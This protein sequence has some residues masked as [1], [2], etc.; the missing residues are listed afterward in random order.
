M[1]EYRIVELES[2]EYEIQRKFLW[3][4]EKLFRQDSLQ[5]AQEIVT[6]WREDDRKRAL[7][8][9]VRRVI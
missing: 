2:D 4:W 1:T 9:I 6:G 7:G 5:E 3:W 8:K